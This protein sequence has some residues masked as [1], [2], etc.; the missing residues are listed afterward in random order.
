MKQN[1]FTK[2]K[3][4]FLLVLLLSFFGFIYE[5][6]LSIIISNIQDRGFL[7]LPF[8]MI[9]GISIIFIYLTIGIPQNIKIFKFKIKVNIF[10]KWLLY[11]IIFSLICTISELIGGFIFD[12]LFNVKLWDYSQMLY[13]YKGYIALLP[14]VVWGI[15][16]S[17][18]M[19]FVFIP[20]KKL[21]DNL[22]FKVL[23]IV[24]YT[25]L[26]LLLIDY[27]FNIVYLIKNGFHFDI[28]KFLSK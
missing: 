8:C 11:I 15:A 17:I 22:S 24:F 7:I 5:T 16:G 13:N 12:K 28:I 6:I 10:I 26:L 3:Q 25:L 4:F 1:K 23:N 9:Y 20:I 18:F 21:V 27:A 14:S 2:F 19:G